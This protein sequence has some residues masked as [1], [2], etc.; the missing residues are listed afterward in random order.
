MEGFY[1]GCDFIFT[2]VRLGLIFR[3]LSCMYDPRREL[4]TERIIQGLAVVSLAALNAWNDFLGPGLFSNLFLV[5]IAAL[6][7]LFGIV[8]YELR[9][10]R[11]FYISFVFMALVALADFFFLSLA[12]MGLRGL[13]K[14]AD[15]LM[16]VGV[17][18]GIYLLILSGT[19]LCVT[20][21]FRRWLRKN[22]YLWKSYWENRKIGKLLILLILGSSMFYFQRVY[23]LLVSESYML[24]MVLF[25]LSAAFGTVLAIGHQAR[26]RME[27]KERQQQFRLQLIEK[28]YQEM[29]TVQREKSILIH[30]MKNHLLV[31]HKLAEKGDLQ[32]VSDYI[33]R[34]CGGLSGGEERVWSGHPMLD[35]I[36]NDKL[37]AAK[38]E[39]IRLDISC[40]RVSDMKLSSLEVC[41]L[42]ANM[43]DNAI[44]ANQ[45]LKEWEERWIRFFCRRQ[46]YML[47]VSISNP[48]KKMPDFTDGFLY[49][50]KREKKGHGLGLYSIQ[51]VLDAHD[52]YMSIGAEG[53]V[54]EL[55]LDLVG[56]DTA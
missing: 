37:R 17:Y 25:I 10:L 19:V 42:F 50:T 20:E 48:V 8:L 45:N 1:Y 21:K 35:L 34:L 55:M 2:A 22:R 14:T 56:F 54:F 9:F 3:L 12:Y 5:I 30:D 47:A 53:G 39:G 16:V 31:L 24:L 46:K 49:T 36:L 41:A 15:V 38:R 18:R 51:S 43:L 23:I 11:V 33:D 13:G 26:R 4:F 6:L 28:N 7:S 40:D 27:E 29:L 44:E 32:G 52:G